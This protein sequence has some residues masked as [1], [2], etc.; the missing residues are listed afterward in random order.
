MPAA[1]SAAFGV[2]GVE[3]MRRAFGTKTHSTGSTPDAVATIT[4]ASSLKTLPAIQVRAR[5]R[6]AC[7]HVATSLYL[8]SCRTPCVACKSFRR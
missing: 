6:V 3:A 1:M 4:C 2:E 8:L 5:D 7:V